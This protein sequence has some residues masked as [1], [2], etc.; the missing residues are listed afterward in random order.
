MKTAL[1]HIISLDH[2]QSHLHLE[3]TRPHMIISSAV[4]NGGI[5]E[6]DRILNLKVDKHCPQ[7]ESPGVTLANYCK[8]QSWGGTAVGMMTAASMD[9][10]RI[11][12]ASEQGVDINVL[13]TVG[14]S[15]P[16]RAGD[17]ADQR[18]ITSQASEPGTINIIVTT[19]AILT[20]PAMVEALMIVTE[21]KAATMQELGV[22][23]PVSDKIATGTGT[24]ASAIISGHGP[25]QIR[26]CG[27][28][29]L[30]GEIL[31]TL[32]FKAVRSSSEWDLSQ[33]G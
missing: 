32:V 12:K 22:R 4:L 21:A 29:V 6:A 10:L 2:T 23:S 33:H 18:K 30:F 16:R 11:T 9:S 20:P 1:N 17:R 13:V 26:Y 28:H 14:L 5:I 3:F 25:E 8:E 27:K 19:S 24:D 7:T 31:A 15:N